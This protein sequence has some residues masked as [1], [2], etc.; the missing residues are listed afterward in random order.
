MDAA[1]IE[2]AG[3]NALQSARQLFYDGWLL[4]RSPGKAKR[5]RSVNPHFGS[6]RPLSEKIEHCAAIYARHG[7]PLL[8]R[9]TPFVQPPDLDAA[10]AAQGYGAFDQT[11]VMFA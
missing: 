7:L 6:T 3:L 10:L 5:A 8:F 4:R 1:R 9:I 11:L 2:D